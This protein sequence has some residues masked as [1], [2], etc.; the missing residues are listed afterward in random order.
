[1]LADDDLGLGVGVPLVHA[2]ALEIAALGRR[3]GGRSKGRDVFG[4]QGGDVGGRALVVGV[5][6]YRDWGCGAAVGVDPVGGGRAGGGPVAL[7]AVVHVAV[8][9]GL[10]IQSRRSVSGFVDSFSRGLG[11]SRQSCIRGLGFARVVVR[12]AFMVNRTFEIAVAQR[13]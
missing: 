12:V 5:L 13:A 2:R 10:G 11:E 7:V 3:E 8:C 9:V 1:M 4:Q 6:L